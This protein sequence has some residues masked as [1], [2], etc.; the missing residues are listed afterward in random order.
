[1][2]DII[3]ND[4][5]FQAHWHRVLH[6]NTLEIAAF[7]EGKKP[8]LSVACR[9]F[10]R[11]QSVSVVVV[12]DVRTQSD[13]G[14]IDFL[15]V[16]SGAYSRFRQLDV[17]FPITLCRPTDNCRAPTLRNNVV[18]EFVIGEAE[19]GLS[20]FKRSYIIEVVATASSPSI[21]VLIGF[22]CGSRYKQFCTIIN[23][24]TED[25]STQFWWR[26]AFTDDRLNVVAPLEGIAAKIL[27]RTWQ[28]YL[29]ELCIGKCIVTNP[30]QPLREIDAL[31]V[32]AVVESPI[33]NENNGGGQLH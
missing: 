13:N 17:A 14:K 27:Q 30:H 20:F 12:E 8:V 4:R 2:S 26:S 33:A 9:N 16:F 3:V 1:M 7:V 10:N 15:T 5:I 28:H 21:R 32:V 19:Q 31:Q 25:R 11:S 6:K 23:I 22:K 24:G 29:R 18:N